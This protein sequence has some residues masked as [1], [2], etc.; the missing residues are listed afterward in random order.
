M[1]TD[2][3]GK[4]HFNTQRANAADKFNESKPKLEPPAAHGD[5]PAPEAKDDGDVASHLSAL[6]AASGGKHIH[7]HD[8]GLGTIT[9]HHV[10]EDGE[11]QGPHNHE[12]IEALKQHM[13]QFL[14]EEGGEDGNPQASGD[15]DYAHDISGL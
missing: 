6:H 10:G 14:N 3:S 4:Y 11:V 2:K 1:P 15:Q 13:D 7:V 9:S 12:N 5:T 8:D